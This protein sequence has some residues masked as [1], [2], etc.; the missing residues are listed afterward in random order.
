MYVRVYIYTISS[1]TIDAGEEIIIEI[2][3]FNSNY[4]NWQKK[5]WIFFIFIFKIKK[6][7]FTV[8]HRVRLS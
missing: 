2:G 5:M 3:S 6:F 8:F 1:Y 4:G 7:I